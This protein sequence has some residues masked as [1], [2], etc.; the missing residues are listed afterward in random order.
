MCF[1]NN[2]MLL[3]HKINYRPHVY[4]NCEAIESVYSVMHCS[5][6][7]NN[8]GSLGAWCMQPQIHTHTHR[9]TTHSHTYT[10]CRLILYSQFQVWGQ[11]VYYNNKQQST[12][13]VKLSLT[14]DEQ[15]LKMKVCTGPYLSLI[16][17]KH[18]YQLGKTI[19]VL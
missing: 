3:H 1:A 4:A 15:S 17:E 14:T 5:F 11:Y 13:P 18:I 16:S 9:C 10:E 6:I 2:V 8:F 7:V 19:T 12:N